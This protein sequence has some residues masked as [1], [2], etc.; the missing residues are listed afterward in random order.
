MKEYNL[1]KKKLKLKL[2]EDT[3]EEIYSNQTWSDLEGQC[4]LLKLQ[5]I[6]K[7]RF[8]LLG[9][10][11]KSRRWKC[12]VRL[13]TPKE[14]FTRSVHDLNRTKREFY[15]LPVKESQAVRLT[16]QVQ[17]TGLG[18]A[19]IVAPRRKMCFWFFHFWL[20]FF[21]F[22]IMFILVFGFLLSKYMTKISLILRYY[23][24]ML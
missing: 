14:N 1:W 21:L 4:W 19:E 3:R 11:S 5:W 15:K 18:D 10:D 22:W 17:S 9:L 6:E 20:K 12:V 2:G 16:V 24:L 7:E 8:Y 23:S 13:K